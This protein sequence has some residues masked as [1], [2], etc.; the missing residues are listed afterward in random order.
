MHNPTEPAPV[1]LAI[2]DITKEEYLKLN[3]NDRIS[4]CK[5]SYDFILNGIKTRL[6]Y[7]Y[8][9]GHIPKEYVDERMNRLKAKNYA[10]PS[11][12]IVDNLPGVDKYIKMK[13][14]TLANELSTD[15][16]K[17]IYLN[18]IRECEENRRQFILR[19]YFVEKGITAK[20]LYDINELKLYK[21]TDE[22]LNKQKDEI[23]EI[24][25]HLDIESNNE[26]INLPKFDN[27]SEIANDEQ[28]DLN[29]ILDI[30]IEDTVDVKKVAQDEIE[31][32]RE[33]DHFTKWIN[34]LKEVIKEEIGPEEYDM[35]SIEDNFKY[36][37]V[38]DSFNFWLE[39]HIQ[40]LEMIFEEDN[41]NY[42]FSNVTKKLDE[43]SKSIFVNEIVKYPEYRKYFENE[44]KQFS[45]NPYY[46]SDKI[47]E[48]YDIG[49]ENDELNG[50]IKQLKNDLKEEVIEADD[51]S[52]AEEEKE[53]IITK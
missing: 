16:K 40:A 44:I 9:R 10:I 43:E 51:I 41:L 32:I 23:N 1:I 48:N 49:L 39:D 50:F 52:E 28:M 33:N 35:Q 21:S 11:K 53:K 5:E 47:D 4:D 27:I 2:A 20:R 19:N 13:Y 8:S 26:I 30:N 22:I 46:E 15:E 25:K 45:Y 24:E 14:P 12:Y 6:E 42:V 36:D 18:Y 3:I 7:Y 17:D 31:Y 37:P 38:E 34:N 29:D